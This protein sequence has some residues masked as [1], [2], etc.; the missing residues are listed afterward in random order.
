[1]FVTKSRSEEATRKSAAIGNKRCLDASLSFLPNHDYIPRREEIAVEG[2]FR[3]RVAAQ[4]RDP[5]SSS[6][7]NPRAADPRRRKAARS[8]CHCLCRPCRKP[9]G[10]DRSIRR[11]RRRARERRMRTDVHGQEH[12]GNVIRRA[13]APDISTADRAGRRSMALESSRQVERSYSK[14]RIL[15]L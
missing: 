11:R 13:R 4:C 1:M 7:I 6:R 9:V 3:R 5:L 10:P 15:D 12:H 14:L 2:F 8:F